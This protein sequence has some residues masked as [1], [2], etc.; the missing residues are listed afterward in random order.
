[1]FAIFK[2]D[3]SVNY[4]ILLSLAELFGLLSVILV[5]LFFD[6]H[7]FSGTYNWKTNSFSFHPLM[8]TMGLLFCY[9]NA[10]LLYRTL[11]QTPKLTVKILH[12]L[13]LIL[14]LAFGSVGFAAIVRS[15]NLG[16]RPHFMTF[17]SW[18]GL[19]TLILFV[20]Q[21]ICGFVSFL[22]PKL[23]LR[24]RNSYMPIHRFWGRIIFLSA[25]ISILT[26]LSQHGMTSSYFTDN[27]VQ[28]KRRLIM[29]FFG[30]FTTLFSLIVVY[31][32]TN[33]DYQRPPDET[34]DE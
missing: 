11:R 12:A 30:V 20:L 32:L 2:R 8:M 16:K 15:K 23:S 5:G 14:S 22:F 17:H 26:G 21:W 27:D 33:P 6:K 31:L 28:R 1:M 4:Q 34:T 25:V 9:G 7:V 18:L 10:I 13:F 3:S 29:D 19:S 24:I